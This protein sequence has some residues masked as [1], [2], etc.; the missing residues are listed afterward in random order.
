MAGIVY[1]SPRRRLPGRFQSF[2]R[3]L[4][5]KTIKKPVVQ[6]KPFEGISGFVVPASTSYR[7]VYSRSPIFF[8]GCRIGQ[9]KDPTIIVDRAQALEM[10]TSGKYAVK[11]FVF[12]T[13]HGNLAYCHFNGSA[14]GGYMR[15]TLL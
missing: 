9:F 4:R 12:R 2:G 1:R 3:G 11:G 14:K 7:I 13:A 15:K 6:K 5:T 8:R 10:V